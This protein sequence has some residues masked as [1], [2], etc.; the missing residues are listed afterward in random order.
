VTAFVSNFKPGSP[1]RGNC[2]VV[3]AIELSCRPE[4]GTLWPIGWVSSWTDAEWRAMTA[5][6]EAGCM[7]LTL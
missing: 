7:E 6:N 4:D 5:I 2:N 1:D 3:G